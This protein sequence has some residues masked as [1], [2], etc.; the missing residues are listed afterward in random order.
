MNTI[1]NNL[2]QSSMAAQSEQSVTKIETEPKNVQNTKQRLQDLVTT[3][4]ESPSLNEKVRFGFHDESETYFVS[5]IDAK[6]DEVIRK[7]PSDEAMNLSKM[8]YQFSGG[9]VDM[10]G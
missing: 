5:I 8:V 4:N 7:Y 9:A 10:R 1:S 2:S 6:T 3:L